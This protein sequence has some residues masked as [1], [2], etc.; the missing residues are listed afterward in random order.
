MQG[1]MRSALNGDRYVRIGGT[2]VQ[3]RADCGRGAFAKTNDVSN[4][5]EALM[6]SEPRCGQLVARV[7]SPSAKDQRLAPAAF[8]R[9][10]KAR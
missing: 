1:D 3:S 7:G 10:P 8:Y 2:L 9:A 5:P 6:I 4:V